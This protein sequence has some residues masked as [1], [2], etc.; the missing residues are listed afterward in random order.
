MRIKGEK[1]KHRLNALSI[2]KDY[3][4][5]AQKNAPKESPT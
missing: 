4:F 3:R 1:E 5:N 2:F